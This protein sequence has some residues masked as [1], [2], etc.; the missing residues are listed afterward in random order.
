MNAKKRK[1]GIPENGSVRD[2]IGKSRPVMARGTSNAT[3]QR[4]DGG[5]AEENV[6]LSISILETVITSFVSESKWMIGTLTITG[7]AMLQ[8][9]ISLYCF[10]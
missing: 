10:A 7:F 1:F 4:I 5:E 8:S 6:D 9:R 3:K 2:E